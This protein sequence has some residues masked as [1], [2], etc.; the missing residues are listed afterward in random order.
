MKLRK[1]I[2]M[3]RYH[4]KTIVPYYSRECVK[5]AYIYG[6]MLTGNP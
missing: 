3:D 5:V 4:S 1:D 6:I 2:D